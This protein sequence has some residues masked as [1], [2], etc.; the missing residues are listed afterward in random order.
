VAV[1]A[2]E[3]SV[4]T[5]GAAGVMMQLNANTGATPGRYNAPRRRIIADAAS[6]RRRAPSRITD[7]DLTPSMS[8]KPGMRQ[9]AKT[10]NPP[11]CGS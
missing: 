3:R 2:T 5:M 6:D 8:L 11:R 10:V 4:A 1:K 7:H 9:S